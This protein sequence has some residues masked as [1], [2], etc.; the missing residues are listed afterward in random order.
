MIT[1]SKCD[2][3]FFF[4]LSIHTALATVAV[5]AGVVVRCCGRR[6][7]KIRSFK[8]KYAHT[9]KSINPDTYH[10]TAHS[11]LYVSVM[12]VFVN[13]STFDICGSMCV[14]ACVDIRYLFLKCEILTRFLYL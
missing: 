3:S 6:I 9:N 12:S 13:R 10:H 1:E 11:Y 4:L 14:F 8:N 5:G 2:F 7:Q